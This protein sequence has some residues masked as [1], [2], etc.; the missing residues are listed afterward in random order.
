MAWKPYCNRLRHRNRAAALIV[1]PANLPVPARSRVSAR[2]LGLRGGSSLLRGSFRGLLRLPYPQQGVL[3]DH[4]GDRTVDAVLAV[5]PGRLAPAGAG[6]TVLLAQ[7]RQ[8]DGRLLF[9]EPGQGLQPAQHLGPVGLTPGP[10][11]GGVTVVLGD[12]HLAQRLD[13]SSEERR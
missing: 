1:E 3:I 10:Q 4:I 12:D 9:A 5:V 7:Q 2:V 6:E 8:E 13:P 11:R